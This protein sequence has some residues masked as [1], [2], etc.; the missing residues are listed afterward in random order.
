M[1]DALLLDF[2]SGNTACT[3]ALP[4]DHGNPRLTAALPWGL[5]M[6]GP[7]MWQPAAGCHGKSP[8][9]AAIGSGACHG[10]CHVFFC[11]HGTCGGIVCKYLPWAAHRSMYHTMARAMATLTVC[12][13]SGPTACRG[14]P[15]RHAM[16]AHGNPPTPDPTGRALVPPGPDPISVPCFHPQEAERKA[17][18]GPPATLIPSRR[19]IRDGSRWK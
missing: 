19:C 1:D 2:F 4:V 5:A 9:R 6:W 8:T 13:E 7:A 14:R 11:A 3:M 15:P 16:S 12:H 17:A 10:T 18:G